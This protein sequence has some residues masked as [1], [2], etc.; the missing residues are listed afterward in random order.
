M[1]TNSHRFP[2]SGRRPPPQR[3]RPN[4]RQESIAGQMVLLLF[5]ALL[6]AALAVL[7]AGC[8]L[9]VRNVRD[10]AGR[11][12]PLLAAPVGEIVATATSAALNPAV[13]QPRPIDYQPQP[14]G[15]G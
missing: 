7:L 10:D 4:H 14:A 6:L 1:S 11:P 5:S 15:T 9:P 8:A 2:R 12:V 13:P 3:I